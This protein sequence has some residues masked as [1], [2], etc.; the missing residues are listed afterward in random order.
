[1]FCGLLD[2]LL[3][4]DFCFNMYEDQEKQSSTADRGGAT[5]HDLFGPSILEI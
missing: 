5:F 2:W 3:A 4:V 1:M